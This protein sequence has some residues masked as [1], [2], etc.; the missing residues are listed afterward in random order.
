MTVRFSGEEGTMGEPISHILVVSRMTTFC[1]NAIYLG[2]S[3]SRKYN[4]HLSIVHAMFNPFAM[5]WSLPMI[6]MEDE[7]KKALER[8]K[9][10]LDDIIQ[11]KRTKGMRIDEYVRYGKPMD[12]IMAILKQG[13]ID[14]VI[15]HAHSHSHLDHII[16]GYDYEDVVRKASCSV[17]LVKGDGEER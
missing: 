2:M 1:R 12:E 10:I 14:L 3:L 7:Y 13:G 6:S 5:G 4:A 15:L 11:E 17:L 8:E 16:Y 9:K